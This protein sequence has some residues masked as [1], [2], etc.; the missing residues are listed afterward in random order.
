MKSKESGPERADAGRERSILETAFE[1]HKQLKGIQ[2]QI[3]NTKLLV[4]KLKKELEEK[5]LKKSQQELELELELEEEGDSPPEVMRIMGSIK[6]L[7]KKKADLEKLEK[8]IKTNLKRL[9][10]EDPQVGLLLRKM[11]TEMIQ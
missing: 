10:K 5:E 9:E 8:R 7:E 1:H 4:E 6:T 11:P 2:G 3:K